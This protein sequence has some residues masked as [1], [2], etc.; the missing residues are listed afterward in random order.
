MVLMGHFRPLVSVPLALEYESV[1]TRPEQLAVSR[2]SLNEAVGIVKAFCRLGEVVHLAYGLRPQLE[3]PDDEFVLET[4]FHGNAELIVTFNTRDFRRA[5]KRFGI[6]AI[7]P[8]EM[9]ERMRKL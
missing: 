1:L 5:V 8:R 6:E 3:D 2:L 7:S 9:V 4:A